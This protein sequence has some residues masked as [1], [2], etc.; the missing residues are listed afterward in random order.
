MVPNY[1]CAGCY[2]ARVRVL[3]KFIS[4]RLAVRWDT[5]DEVEEVVV[6]SFTEEQHEPTEYQ[7][8]IS[9]SMKCCNY[10]IFKFELTK[11]KLKRP[12]RDYDIFNPVV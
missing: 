2:D 6:K 12:V 5:L 9:F 4:R 8:C 10:G 11:H 3:I 7:F 1:F